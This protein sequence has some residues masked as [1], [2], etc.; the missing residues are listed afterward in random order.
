LDPPS[1]DL[2]W[3]PQVVWETGPKE[4]LSKGR[5][6]QHKQENLGSVTAKEHIEHLERR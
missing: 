3:T 6:K 2:T 1:R 5:P 4:S